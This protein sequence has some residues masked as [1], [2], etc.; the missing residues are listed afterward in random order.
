M[1]KMAASRACAVCLLAPVWVSLAAHG[2]SV[3]EKSGVNATLGISPSTQDFVTQAA[4]SDA[5]EIATAKVAEQKGDPGEKKFAEEMITDH[6]RTSEELEGLVDSGDINAKLPAD[7]NDSSKK[8]LTEL[9]DA[10]PNDFS[11]YYDPMQVKAHKDAVSLFE[12][13]AKSGD[14]AKLKAW[15]GKTLPTLQHH[16]QMAQ[17]L[18]NRD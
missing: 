3:G 11:R 17:S 9:Q 13:Y 1:N 6:T 4:H 2:Q 18:K 15:A 8:K 16:L 7:L 5:L 14:D 12:R 10:K